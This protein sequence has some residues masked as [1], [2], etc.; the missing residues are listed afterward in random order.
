MVFN[1]LSAGNE[2]MDSGG[3]LVP[4]VG[5]KVSDF[6][7]ISDF[8]YKV[9]VMVT[10]NLIASRV[11]IRISDAEHFCLAGPAFARYRR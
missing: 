2:V 11:A 9:F 6:D 4:A 5:V 1:G 3:A 8:V 10:A 7:G